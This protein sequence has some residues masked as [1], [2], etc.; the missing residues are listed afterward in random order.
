MHSHF[1]QEKILWTLNLVVAYL[2]KS[3]DA[4]WISAEMKKKGREREYG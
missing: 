2:L 3:E 4:I 1:S